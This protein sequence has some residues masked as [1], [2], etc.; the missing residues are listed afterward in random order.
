MSDAPQI[1]I[2][3]LAV[4]EK[5]LFSRKP[6]IDGWSA[7]QDKNEALC[8]VSRDGTAVEIKDASEAFKCGTEGDAFFAVFRAP[9]PFSLKVD[10]GTD[11]EGFKW[12]F[13]VA[14]FV[15]LKR[16][17][18]FA[19]AFRGI[20]AEEEPYSSGMLEKHFGTITS[21]IMHDNIICGVLG[22]SALSDKDAQD[23]YVDMQYRL[24]QSKEV[25]EKVVSSAIG[26]AFAQLIGSDDAV[27]V[28]VTTFHA[29]SADRE[30]ALM[31]DE[32]N[33]VLIRN[34]AIEIAKLQ[35]D[36]EVAKLNNEK[37][38]VEA[39]TVALN[40]K[41]KAFLDDA[42]AIDRLMNMNF[43]NGKT[44]DL[45]KV[46]AFL[47]KE[48]AVNSIMSAAHSLSQKDSPVTL[49]LES[50]VA[51]RRIGPRREVMKQG[52]L[53]GLEIV[54]SRDG[55]LTVLDV[56]DGDVIVPVVPCVDSK[57]KSAF[58]CAGRK[59]EIGRADSPWIP[60][61]FEQYDNSGTDRFVAFVTEK[62]LLSF[63]ESVPFGEE[64]PPESIRTLA[65]RIAALQSAGASGGVLQ[66]RIETKR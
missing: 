26:D 27:E 14:G 2:R 22:V 4:K 25:G 33:D 61:S 53:Y 31:D 45:G 58:V 7:K 6:V 63:D 49:R 32:K 11:A 52:G 40:A 65:E 51:T 57:T 30:A 8:R 9:F 18:L 66:V 64:L 23:R 62:P 59:V 56:C 39:D 36:I 46:L 21:T 41:T 47:G 38:K 1:L 48:D 60:E 20:V 43:A 15:T 35:H 28:N 34:Q 54:S 10:G 12:M 24:E 16:P 50:G 5:G 19:S 37:A 17:E 13:D 3:Q 55:H 29:T 42:E 44:P